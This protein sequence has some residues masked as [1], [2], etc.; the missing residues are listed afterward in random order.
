MAVS[1]PFLKILLTFFDFFINECE[2]DIFKLCI[3]GFVSYFQLSAIEHLGFFDLF[4]I[5]FMISYV[6]EIVS[7]NVEKWVYIEKGVAN[8][9]NANQNENDDVD[10]VSAHIR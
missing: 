1:I 8:V 2:V 9:Y 3:A 7:Q 10:K 6:V 4:L 5:L